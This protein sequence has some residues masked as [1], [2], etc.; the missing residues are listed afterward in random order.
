MIKQLKRILL[1]K[2]KKYYYKNNPS[3]KDFQDLES[4]YWKLSHQMDGLA[5][6]LDR[7]IIGDT[8]VTTKDAKKYNKLNGI[9]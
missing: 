8:Y 1:G 5:R 4:K 6:S 7:Q 9:Y 2:K 3:W